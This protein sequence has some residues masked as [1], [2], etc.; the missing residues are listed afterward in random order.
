MAKAAKKEVR[1][2]QPKHVLAQQRQELPIFTARE[3]LL[4]EIDKHQTVIGASPSPCLPIH[5]LHQ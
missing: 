3:R 1:K 2:A 4:Q 5:S